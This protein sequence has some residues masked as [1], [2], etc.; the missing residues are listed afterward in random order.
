MNS[1]A[2]RDTCC[3]HSQQSRLLGRDGT[4]TARPCCS[5]LYRPFKSVPKKH[6]ASK[7]TGPLLRLVLIAQQRGRSLG[8]YY[9]A[10]CFSM[11]TATCY[12]DT[13]SWSRKFLWN[14]APFL[15]IAMHSFGTHLVQR[16]EI[17]IT[18]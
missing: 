12:S 10:L 6:N 15:C 5:S 14:I 18:N 17:G 13:V 7:I 4:I 8:L 2:G 16:L 3:S 9:I 11:P 1:D